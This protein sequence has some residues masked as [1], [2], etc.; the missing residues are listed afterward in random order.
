MLTASHERASANYRLQSRA[1]QTLHLYMTQ[2]G[3]P[4]KG[5]PVE[6]YW[7]GSYWRARAVIE[8]LAVALEKAERASSAGTSQR[9]LTA[10]GLDGELEPGMPKVFCPFED[11]ESRPEMK[12]LMDD[13]QK[14]A[15][16]LN[17][18]W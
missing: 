4:G 12:A 6:Y 10:V 18:N 7:C 14:V 5:G 11:G 8:I 9:G 16:Q 1:I 15:D 13:F 3:S 17:S 2:S